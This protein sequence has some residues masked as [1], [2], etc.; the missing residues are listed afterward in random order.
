MGTALS[1]A[2]DGCVLAELS[3]DGR[4]VYSTDSMEGVLC[5]RGWDPEEARVHVARVT[6]VTRAGWPDFLD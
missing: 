4:L 1:P 5:A 2:C 3:P 6:R